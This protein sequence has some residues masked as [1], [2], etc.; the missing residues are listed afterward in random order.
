MAVLTL[1]KVFLARMLTFVEPAEV[2]IEAIADL[3]LLQSFEEL[4]E[5]MLATVVFIGCLAFLAMAPL[6][7]VG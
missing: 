2:L 6:L 5:V 3:V 7:E 4:S 1:E